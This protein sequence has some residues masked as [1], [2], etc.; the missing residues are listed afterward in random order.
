MVDQLE[1]SQEARKNAVALANAKQ[2]Q[3]YQPAVHQQVKL[4]DQQLKSVDQQLKPSDQ[5]LRS[6]VQL[7]SF[8]QL[9]QASVELPDG[10]VVQ[11]LKSAEQTE[12]ADKQV[13]P[14][15]E[16]KPIEKHPVEKQPI[17]KQARNGDVKIQVADAPPDKMEVVKEEEE[18]SLKSEERR[19]SIEADAD[20]DEE[21]MEALLSHNMRE[22]EIR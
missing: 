13:K 6:E 8:N 17:E 22:T 12:D 15:D 18:K 20:E 21:A 2:S 16:L 11:Q 19:I 1:Y 10:D 4:V 14:A 7:K 3:Q 5:P 9:R